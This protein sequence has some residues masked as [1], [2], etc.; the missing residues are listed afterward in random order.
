M[1]QKFSSVANDWLHLSS[2]QIGGV[3]WLLLYL[4]WT[5]LT[6]ILAA[7]FGYWHVVCL[8]LSVICDVNVLWQNDEAGITRFSL[9]T[10]SNAR[11]VNV[12]SSTRKFEKDP[13]IGDSNY[14]GVVCSGLRSA[15][16]RKRRKRELRLNL[17]NYPLRAIFIGATVMTFIELIKRSK[18]LWSPKHRFVLYQPLWMRDSDLFP[19]R[20]V[21]Q[22]TDYQ[23]WMGLT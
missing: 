2:V 14:G 21:V 11:T 13:L 16:S 15:M 9:E 3:R 4:L 17:H 23:L 5:R 19:N 8:R 12:A 20:L 22:M 1:L 7:L 6:W 10:S 18:S